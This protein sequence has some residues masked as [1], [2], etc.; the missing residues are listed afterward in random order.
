MLLQ[1]TTRLYNGAQC[2]IGSFSEITIMTPDARLVIRLTPGPLRPRVGDACMNELRGGPET[3]LRW[4]E[5]KL[6]LPV[7]PIHNAS[8]ITEYA[9]PLI[10]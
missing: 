1:P 3:L 6:G 4:L 7:S 2:F 8:R 9:A 5:T 10:L